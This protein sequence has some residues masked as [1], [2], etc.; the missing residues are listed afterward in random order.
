MFNQSSSL[1]N[2]KVILMYPSINPAKVHRLMISQRYLSD[3]ISA[4]SNKC[5]TRR[6]DIEMPI[7]MDVTSPFNLGQSPRWLKSVDVSGSAMGGEIIVINGII[8]AEKW[9]STI[10]HTTVCVCVKGSF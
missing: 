8:F 9:T 10:L 2:G 6:R 7:V 1:A 4:L 3:T 5:V